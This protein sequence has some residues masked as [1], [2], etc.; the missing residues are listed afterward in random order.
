[1]TAFSIVPASVLE[2]EVVRDKPEI[3]VDETQRLLEVWIKKQLLWPSELHAAYLARDLELVHAAYFVIYGSGH[4]R[5]SAQVGE[6]KTTRKFCWFCMGMGKK[7]S[8]RYDM[9]TGSYRS[10]TSNCNWCAGHGYREHTTT[11]WH[12]ESGVAEAALEGATWI[13]VADGI[14]IKCGPPYFPSSQYAISCPSQTSIHLIPPATTSNQDA[15]LLARS[16]VQQEVRNQLRSIQ[17]SLGKVQN[18]HE[19]DII[20]P[21]YRA[22]TYLYPIYFCFYK[23]RGKGFQIQI[24]GMTGSVYVSKPAMVTIKQICFFNAAIILTVTLL[25]LIYVLLL[26]F[27]VI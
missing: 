8:S 23:Y 19:G 20:V 18:W 21:E 16:K 9:N 6:D 2:G 1:M 14:K 22:S 24:D 12:A 11:T 15:I 10:D 27:N 5:W 26:Q 4:A 7:T 13:N 25:Y 3:D 17:S